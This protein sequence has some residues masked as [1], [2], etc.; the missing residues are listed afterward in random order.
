MKK[1]LSTAKSVT[2]NH[3]ASITLHMT[4]PFNQI[5]NQSIEH[6]QWTKCYDKHT[7]KGSMIL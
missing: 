7:Q 2:L 1:F 6:R 5:I 3:T 4:L